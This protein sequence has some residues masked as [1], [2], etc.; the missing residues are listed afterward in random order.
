MRRELLILGVKGSIEGGIALRRV[1][2]IHSGA[3]DSRENTCALAASTWGRTNAQAPI[4]PLIRSV[5]PHVTTPDDLGALFDERGNQAR[6]LRVVDDRDIPLSY[7]AADG[8]E[9]RAS[10]RS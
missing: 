9:V 2:S 6:R 4:R 7:L 10:V 5:E 1:R 8:L 3:N